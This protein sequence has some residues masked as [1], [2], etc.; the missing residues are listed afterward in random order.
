MKEPYYEQRLRALLDA[1]GEARGHGRASDRLEI[2]AALAQH[3]VGTLLL[4]SDR[5]IAGSLDA[6]QG[7]ITYP[8]GGRS[9][10]RGDPGSGDVLDF[11]EAALRTGSEVIVLEADRMPAESAAAAVFRY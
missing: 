8:E 11:A 5:R 1:C 6:E 10:R 2:A 7:S 9:P 3:R 4:A